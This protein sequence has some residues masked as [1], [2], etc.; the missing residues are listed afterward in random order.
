MEQ[1][2][3]IWPKVPGLIMLFLVLL[4]LCY[5]HLK[6]GKGFLEGFKGEN[7]KWD[8]PEVIVFIWLE[9]WVAA[10]LADI[11][12]GLVASDKVW[13]GFDLILLFVLGFKAYITKHASKKVEQ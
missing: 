9:L 11:F 12:L 13:Y 7:K 2:E 3:I 6:H 1:S 10:V 8:T 5:L 4:R